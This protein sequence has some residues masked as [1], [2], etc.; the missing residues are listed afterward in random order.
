M[1]NHNGRDFINELYAGVATGAICIFSLPQKQSIWID[2]SEKEKI[3][4]VLQEHQDKNVY[5][6]LC[7]SIHPK[8]AYSRT[9]REDASCLPSVVVDVDVY[10]PNAHT[11]TKL[12]KTKEEALEFIEDLP[13]PEPSA[14]I[15]SGNGYQAHWFFD[16][17][18]QLVDD[19]ARKKAESISF[20]INQVVIDEGQKRGW[21]FDNVGDLARVFRAPDTMN[22]KGDVPKATTVI[23]FSCKRYVYA[24]LEKTLPSPLKVDVQELDFSC[25]NEKVELSDKKS[26][27]RAVLAACRFIQR[28]VQDA[29]I[30]P[31]PEWYAGLSIVGRTE[32]GRE[33]SH[34]VSSQY[35]NYDKGKVDKKLEQA[36]TASGPVTCEHISKIG[37][38]GCLACPLFYSKNLKSPISLGYYDA[39]LTELLG[40][41]AYSIQT[42]QFA[43]ARP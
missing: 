26:D 42:A 41:Y 15:D 33:I 40:R 5:L 7:P 2:V 29:K 17:P 11:Q 30:L 10:N 32:N 20:G 24:D 31:E 3:Y 16:E 12:P 35:P 27:F 43:E 4:D 28:W 9:T 13:L 23:D 37:F 18:I 6:G 38:E 14:I 34:R 21:K 39:T 1:K 25:F 19:E 36:L 8:T 22:I